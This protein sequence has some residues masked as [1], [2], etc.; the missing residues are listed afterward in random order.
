MR[1]ATGPWMESVLAPLAPLR[2]ANS[3][4]LFSVMTTERPEIT[5]ET[6]VD[7]QDWTALRFRHK[8]AP[9]DNSL[10]FLP[11]HMPRLDWQMW[12]AALEFR[13]SGQPPAW[14][15][16][17]LQRLSEE[18]GPVQGLLADAPPG[19]APSHFRLRLDRLEFTSPAERSADGQ[20]W[21]VEPLP[22]YTVSGSVRR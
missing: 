19:P 21:K 7:G 17:F 22:E 15:L 16:P 4:G 9:G 12:F 13:S 11:P 20:L 3:Y 14:V 5:V 6:S 8:A 2:S 10:P 18:S 1:V